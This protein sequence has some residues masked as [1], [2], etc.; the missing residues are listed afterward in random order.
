[1]PVDVIRFAFWITVF[2]NGFT[3]VRRIDLRV[4]SPTVPQ[5]FEIPMQAIEILELRCYRGAT[6]PASCLPQSSV[7]AER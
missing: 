7:E 3:E 5:K 2:I 4:P 1:M 6:V